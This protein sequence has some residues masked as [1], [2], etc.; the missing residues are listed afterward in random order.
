[1][2]PDSLARWSRAH[3]AAH[4]HAALESGV[5]LDVCVRH[6]ERTAGADDLKRTLRSLLPCASN[7]GKVAVLLVGSESHAALDDL[8]GLSL[9]WH[10]RVEDLIAAIDSEW[11]TVLGSGV[12]LKPW[13]VAEFAAAVRTKP[14]TDCIYGDAELVDVHGCEIPDLRP[15]WSPILAAHHDYVGRFFFLRRTVLEASLRSA[16]VDAWDLAVVHQSSAAAICVGH[17]P[18]VLSRMPTVTGVRNLPLVEWS[19]PATHKRVSAIIPT[20]VAN[21]PMLRRCVEGLVHATDYPLLDILLV[22]NGEA[23][24][25][26]WLPDQVRCVRWDLPFNWSTVSNHG[27]ANAEGELLLFLND[28]V[29]P[30]SVDWLSRLVS[31]QDASEAAV[32]G[33]LMT[34]PDG[35]VQH[36]GIFLAYHGGGAEHL[37]HGATSIPTWAS[38][39]REVSAVTG[40]VM[41]VPRS[42]FEAVGGFDPQFGLTCNDTDFCLRVRA[43]GGTVLV[44]PRSHLVHHE[45][46]TRGNFDDVG[47]A[48][49]FWARWEGELRRGDPYFNPNLDSASPHWKPNCAFLE[50]HPARWNEVPRCTE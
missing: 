21:E 26:S 43:A 40:A 35:R 10:Y 23:T 44:E 19:E 4:A 30:M 20:R 18:T 12:E 48:L 6:D 31:A 29:E 28:D 17:V 3:G 8:P 41:L 25:P 42:V 36:V 47:D 9:S 22:L 7:F 34:Y 27:A 5:R 2:F 16:H 13:A 15:A 32:V 33:P 38:C 39:P 24:P 50:H 49:R 14:E 37:F 11:L 45:R 46:A 1:M